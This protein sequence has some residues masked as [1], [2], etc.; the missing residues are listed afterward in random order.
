MTMTPEEIYRNFHEGRSD[1]LRVTADQVRTIITAYREL[2][3][4]IATLRGRMA[5]A[6]TGDAAQSATARTDP[7]SRSLNDSAELLDACARSHDAQKAAFDSA[8]SQVREMPPAPVL[9]DPLQVVKELFTHGPTAP[10]DRM[11]D[12]REQ[13]AAHQEAARHNLAVLDEYQRATTDNQDI[14]T[15]Y[16]NPALPTGDGMD[17]AGQDSPVSIAEFADHVYDP[18]KGMIVD[19]PGSTS[20]QG[21]GVGPG[22][23]GGLGGGGGATPGGG[24]G[25]LDLPPLDDGPAQRDLTSASGSGPAVTTV[26]TQPPVTTIHEPPP[27]RIEDPGPPLRLPRDNGA[28]GGRDDSDD[29]N[30]KDRTD[31]RDDQ[32]HVAGAGV[33]STSGLGWPLGGGV[34]RTGGDAGGQLGRGGGVPGTAGVGGGAGGTS[35]PPGPLSTRGGLRAGV[36]AGGPGGMGMGPSGSSRREE[37]REHTRPEYLIEPDPDEIFGSGASASSPV[38][39]AS[40]RPEYDEETDD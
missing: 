38:I 18:G 21:G 12:Y 40:W 13:L 23:T 1:P 4:N 9:P 39:G 8:Q 14:P 17:T 26:H 5:G 24:T 31:R 19:P 34:D 11:A 32:T 3:E 7:L 28:P 10:F 27:T 29:R 25:S 35:V 2:A 33:D 6:W 20:S 22:G 37:D 36:R 30:Q 16:P 15:G